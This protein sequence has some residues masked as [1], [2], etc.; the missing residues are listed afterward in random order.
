M[1]DVTGPI[2]TL[3]GAER[4]SSDGMMCDDHPDRVAY[5]RVQGETDSMGCEMYDLCKEC[6]DAFKAANNDSRTGTCDWCK[7]HQTDLRKH[8]DFEEGSCGPVYDVCGGCVRR[9]NASLEKE[10]EHLGY[11]D[12][13]D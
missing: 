1:A 7:T 2:S 6:Y 10:L 13:D 3:P 8:R 5:K 9:Q 11:Y 4:T 12:Y